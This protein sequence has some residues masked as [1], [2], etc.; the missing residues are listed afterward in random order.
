MRSESTAR[1]SPV[2]AASAYIPGMMLIL[3]V[4]GWIKIPDGQPMVTHWN[5]SGQPNGYSSKPFALLGL[6]VAT[7]ILAG[8]FIPLSRIENL[9][10]VKT[11]VD[12]GPNTDGCAAGFGHMQALGRKLDVSFVMWGAFGLLL[13][14]VGNYFPKLRRDCVSRIRTSR[15]LASELSWYK[16]HRVGGKLFV[17]YGLMVLLGA[18]FLDTNSLLELIIAGILA[19][20]LFLSVYS[21]TVWK[22]DPDCA[23][24]S[25]GLVYR[26]ERI[27][28][29]MVQGNHN[30]LYIGKRSSRYP[31]C[32]FGCMEAV[33]TSY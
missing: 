13:I 8:I 9:S 23:P 6:P 26:P 2:L 18:L 31:L 22:R 19:L 12:C 20:L 30:N 33:S 10:S 27:L 5:A 24:L 15:A 25:F 16:T 28:E 14:P 21:Y 3:T 11:Y 32:C 1:I 4:V 17:L 7:L 29:T